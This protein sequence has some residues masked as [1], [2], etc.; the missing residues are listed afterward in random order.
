MRGSGIVR[1]SP[2]IE[3]PWRSGLRGARA[4]LMAGVALQMAALALVTGY[5]REPSVHALLSRL[6]EVR[7]EAGVWFSM[8]STAVFGGFLPFLYIRYRR[9]EAKGASQYGWV[10]GLLLTLFWGYK[11]L[12]IDLW[13]RL[14]A[15]VVGGGH[16]AATIAVKVVLDQF[17]YCPLFAV[18]VTAAVYHAVELYP[19][20]TGVIA[21]IRTPGWYRRR[22]LPVLIANMGL[23]VPAVAVPLLV[24]Y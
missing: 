12:E 1:S 8:A 11:G 10:Q 6:V 20:W 9:R 24:A 13:Y 17:A 3:P 15:H 16:D 18:P 22:V 5:Y 23:W 7:R 2:S 19:G 14:Q 4:N 21:D